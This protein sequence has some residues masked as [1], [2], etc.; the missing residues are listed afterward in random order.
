[1]GESHKIVWEEI[2]ALAKRTGIWIHNRGQND[3]L[4]R[5]TKPRRW[6]GVK[7]YAFQSTLGTLVAHVAH[8]EK[9]GGTIIGI[10]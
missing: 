10:D 6:G 8:I 5:F 2:Y 3:F 4:I 1:M 7:K 9:I